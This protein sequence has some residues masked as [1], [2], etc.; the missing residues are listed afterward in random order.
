MA[1]RVEYAVSATP[2]VTV[3]PGENTEVDTIAVDVG[4]SIGGSGSSTVTWGTTVGYGSGSPVYVTTATNY[5]V[6]QTAT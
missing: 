5:A 1:S 2:I 4:K 6:G 3:A